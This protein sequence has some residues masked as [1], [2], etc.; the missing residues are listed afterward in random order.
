[1]IIWL[2]S[3]PRSGNTL[4]RTVIKQTM[5][6]GSYSDEIT[7]PI[8]G[9]TDHAKEKFGNLSFEGPWESFYHQA[10]NSE[11][12][13]LVKTH[14]PPRDNQPVIYVIRDG[15]AATE[16]YA[17]YHRRF[18]LDQKTHPSILELM[19]GDD[20]YGDWSSHYRM[21]HARMDARLMLVKF[22][23]LVNADRSLLEKLKEFLDFKGDIKPFQN[24][25]EILHLENPDFFR[26]G[27][28]LWNT[29][30]EWVDEL[31]SLFI[32][33][34][35]KLLLQLDFVSPLEYETALEMSGENAVRL[36]ELANRGFYERNTW[37]A[38]AQAK[39][40]VIQELLNKNSRAPDKNQDRSTL[41]T[42]L[43]KKIKSWGL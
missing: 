5:N 13:F 39:E 14:L 19:L 37:H 7:P 26:A 15:R 4:L 8:V 36:I 6:L 1:M 25:M 3:Y 35:G 10:S 12:V 20:Y 27:K 23:E 22:E 17:A 2:A 21:W 40:R 9:L 30:S 42:G 24:P 33:L 29:S 11:D 41:L 31:E 43:I 28:T 38:V 34:H 32:A 16:S 18:V